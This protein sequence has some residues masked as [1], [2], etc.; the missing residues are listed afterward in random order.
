METNH[1]TKRI[2]DL[3][4]ETNAR[5]ADL[6]QDMN[7]RFTG[8]QQQLSTLQWT[9]NMWLGIITLLIIAFKFIK[10]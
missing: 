4:S 10:F 7:A 8:V 3:R 2:E 9:T 6:R 5:F 1:L